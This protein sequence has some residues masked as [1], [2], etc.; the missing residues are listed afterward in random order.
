LSTGAFHFGTLFRVA[1]VLITSLIFAEAGLAQS[2]P[3]PQ[4]SPAPSWIGELSRNTP[5]EIHS[6][7]VLLGRARYFGNDPSVICGG[8]PAENLRITPDPTSTETVSL[9]FSLPKIEPGFIDCRLR[10]G[11]Q[12]SLPSSRILVMDADGTLTEVVTG[13]AMYQKVE[14]TD[15][16]LDTEHPTLKPVRNARIEVYEAGRVIFTSDTDN[17]G[18]FVVRVP[19]DAAELIIRAVSRL[20]SP[21]LKVED[22]TNGSQ[23]Y[24]ISSADID[25]RE[26]PWR[27][28][29]VDKS[30]KSG[31][32]NILEQIQRANDFVHAADPQFQPFP[33]TI[34]WS[35]RNQKQSGGNIK[36]G[37]IGTTSFSL[38]SSTAYILGDRNTDS[39]E[40]DDSVLIHEYAH[41]LAAKFSRDDSIG[42]WH[43]LG[44]NLD[45]RVAWS[46]GWA[47]FFSG[48]VRNDSVYRDSTGPGG[49]NVIRFDLEDNYPPG[50]WTGYGSETS[51]QALLWDFYD[52]KNEPGDLAQFDFSKMW[53]AFTDLDSNHFVYMQNFLDHLVA[54]NP[55]ASDAIQ[56]MAQ[57]QSIDFQPDEVPSVTN[58]FPWIIAMNSVR[59]GELDSFSTKRMNL[60]QSS[61]FFIF[62]TNGGPL[63][64]QL[65]VAPGTIGIP[66]LND[67]DLYL[68]DS[69]GRQVSKSDSG[70]SGQGESIQIPALLPGSYVIE[71]RSYYTSNRGY[72]VFN[73]GRYKL[74]LFGQ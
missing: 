67:L 17:N 13:N 47:N 51:V 21:D 63:A 45:P 57:S 70:R 44:D 74:S 8:K 6:G 66:A 38:T 12:E 28:S 56:R 52:D 32:F 58:P 2:T 24:Y 42:G 15:I 34:F 19:Q 65:S 31:A 20:L 40:Y 68:Y 50:S 62:S 22:N 11:T 4:R 29:L 43:R 72:T 23:F 18:E 60:A 9:T 49:S 73:S 69:N 61:H 41:M 35:E 64:I 53:A 36:D 14:V 5:G 26:R 1:S 25:R 48:A 71:I 59:A 33:F 27:V 7:D 30:R 54:R 10:N 39:D 46:E 3:S 55:L 37:F 16:G